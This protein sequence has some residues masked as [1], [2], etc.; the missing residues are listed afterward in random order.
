M[1][2]GCT[3]SADNDSDGFT[4]GNDPDCEYAP[5]SIERLPYHEPGLYPAV[6]ACYNGVDDDG[7]GDTDAADPDCVNSEGDP[8]GF[9]QAEDPAAPGCTNGLDDD[10]DSWVDLDDP[11]CDGDIEEL[12]YGLT[13][14]NDGEDND[15]DTLVDAEDP[16][17]TDALASESD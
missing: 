14:C 8:S 1:A 4:D 17:C 9:V 6:P 15:D 16:D 13:D 10:E 2:A 5:Y 7:N 11:D 12:G 3:D